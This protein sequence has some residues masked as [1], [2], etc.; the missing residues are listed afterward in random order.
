M[1]EHELGYMDTDIFCEFLSIKEPQT[2]QNK[3][4]TVQSYQ[5]MSNQNTNKSL[6]IKFALFNCVEKMGMDDY[7]CL[8][9][10]P[11]LY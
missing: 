5:K 3:E 11:S 2:L 7:G 9:S 4:T 10:S 1:T 6:G 8:N